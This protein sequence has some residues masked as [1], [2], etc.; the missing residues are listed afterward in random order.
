MK[1]KPGLEAEYTEYKKL[2]SEDAHFEA[3]V[4]YGEKWADLMEL[5]LAKGENISDFAKETSH[6]ANADDITSFM[7]G[8]TISALAKFWLHGEE[9]RVWHNH[10]T[11]IGTEGDKANANGGT[12]NPALIT[13]S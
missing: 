6:I 10:K 13:I 4:T 1:L 11:Q 7:Y 12:L 8:C 9:L 3:V 5:R 2:N